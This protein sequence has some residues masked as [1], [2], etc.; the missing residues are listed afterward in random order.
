MDRGHLD[1]EEFIA[2]IRHRLIEII[3]LIEEKT[4]QTDPS[5]TFSFLLTNE[6]FFQY[7][8]IRTH[9]QFL[10]HINKKIESFFLVNEPHPEE[11]KDLDNNIKSIFE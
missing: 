10:D 9:E 2:S 8:N 7:D 4:G 1:D 11:P 3:E 5:W 6:E